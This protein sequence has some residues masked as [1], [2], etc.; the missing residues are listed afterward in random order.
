MNAILRD[1]LY[2]MKQQRRDGYERLPEILS[3]P[4]REHIPTAKAKLN[5]L[6]TTD[7]DYDFNLGKLEPQ[8]IRLKQSTPEIVITFLCTNCQSKMRNLIRLRHI[9]RITLYRPCR[10]SRAKQS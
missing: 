4:E 7:S 9:V 8:A 2:A 10:R 6:I 1:K 5:C 3:S